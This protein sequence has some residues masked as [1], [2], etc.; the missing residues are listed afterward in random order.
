MFERVEKLK[1]RKNEKDPWRN[2]AVFC[3]VWFGFFCVGRRRRKKRRIRCGGEGNEGGRWEMG[4]PSFNWAFFLGF[5]SKTPF[6]YPISTFD[7]DFSR[8]SHTLIL[9][10]SIFPS[11]QFSN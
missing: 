10:S 1:R 6:L 11:N 7:F 2:D 5:T 8:D 3:F 4:M 9:I